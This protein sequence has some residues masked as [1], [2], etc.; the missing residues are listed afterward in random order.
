[1]R[2]RDGGRAERQ[3]G[4]YTLPFGIAVS[5]TVCWWLIPVLLFQG[6]P[7]A[8]H[9]STLDFVPSSELP[10]PALVGRAVDASTP[11]LRTAG[12]TRPS[13]GA[14]A[15]G[16]DGCAEKA[17]AHVFARTAGAP[18]PKRQ[19]PAAR[20]PASARY[21]RAEAE[22]PWEPPPPHASTRGVKN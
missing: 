4:A 15:R 8:A 22:A 20:A 13:R 21:R 12:R 7:I 11:Q 5:V 14:A 1:M 9:W 10:R 2:F 6:G 16:G 3:K 18:P 17:V 19:R